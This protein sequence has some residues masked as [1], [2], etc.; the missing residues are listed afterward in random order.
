MARA[1]LKRTN[2]LI[3]D[4]ATARFVAPAILFMFFDLL[5]AALTMPPTN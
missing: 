1:I 3:M 2:V 4:E 5:L